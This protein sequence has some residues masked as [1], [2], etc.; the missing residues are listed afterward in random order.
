M[1][2]KSLAAIV[3]GVSLLPLVVVLV[4]TLGAPGQPGQWFSG[5]AVLLG[6]S[7]FGAVILAGGSPNRAQPDYEA[8]Q[9]RFMSRGVIA[10]ALAVATFA[11]LFGQASELTPVLL[12]GA[13]ILWSLIWLPRAMRGIGIRTSVVIGRDVGTVFNFVSDM[14]NDPLWEP[15]TLTVEKIT[16]GAIG[17]GSQFRAKSATLEGVEEITE[18]HPPASMT[19]RLVT[20]LRPNRTVLTFESVAGGTRI[21]HRFQTEL[22]YPGALLGEGL[23]RWIITA[24]MSAGRNLAWQR[25]KALLESGTSHN[26]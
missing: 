4:V 3:I 20:A 9:G 6:I 15:G 25:L 10:G 17:Q 13:V 22:S 1:Q 21:D 12:S 23:L 2:P 7:G 14:S 8:A 18:F 16:D 26:L 5:A 11:A 19:T 24:N